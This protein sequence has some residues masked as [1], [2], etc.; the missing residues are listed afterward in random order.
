M[1]PNWNWGPAFNKLRD[2]VNLL[3]WLWAEEREITRLFL[4]SFLW[5]VTGERHTVSD[6]AS[7]MGF[8]VAPEGPADDPELSA[9]EPLVGDGESQ[10]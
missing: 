5:A 10:G 1:E 2:D 7:Q 6:F 4:E 3:A 8:G 9:E